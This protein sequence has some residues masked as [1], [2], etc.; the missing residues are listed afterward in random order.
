M[1]ADGEVEGLPKS[2]EK[3]LAINVAPLLRGRHI[4]TKRNLPAVTLAV[5][6][7]RTTSSS[8][9]IVGKFVAVSVASAAGVPIQSKFACMAVAVVAAIKPVVKV[10]VPS[11]NVPPPELI[12]TFSQNT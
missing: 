11:D 9:T 8:V 2:V 4:A 7:V 12:G 6:T 5:A 1:E 3:G 10:G